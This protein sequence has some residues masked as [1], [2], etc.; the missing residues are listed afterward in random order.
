MTLLKDE[1]A[2]RYAENRNLREEYNCIKK[3]SNYAG[4]PKHVNMTRLSYILDRMVLH[5]PLIWGW[6]D[7]FA[8]LPVRTS[9][10]KTIWLKKYWK[11]VE[12]WN[13]KFATESKPENEFHT[14]VEIVSRHDLIMKKLT[15]S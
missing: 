9:N 8:W 4:R 5:Q 11:H 12:V 10:G 2:K 6:V 14:V 7:E 13:H 3:D 15:K 1:L